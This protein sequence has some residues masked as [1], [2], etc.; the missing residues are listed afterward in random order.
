MA[1]DDLTNMLDEMIDAS[2]DVYCGVK[3]IVIKPESVKKVKKGIDLS[4]LHPDMVVKLEV[5]RKVW[6]QYGADIE[7]FCHCLVSGCILDGDTCECAFSLY[8]TLGDCK[9]EYER[10]KV[11]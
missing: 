8:N 6:A 11:A 5:Y 7:E 3:G 4:R 1:N 2:P 9:A 10:E